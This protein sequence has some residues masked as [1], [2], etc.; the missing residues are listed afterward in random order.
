MYFNQSEGEFM[1]DQVLKR[2]IE[3]AGYWFVG[4]YA[5]KTFENYNELV[6][7]NYF[8][9]EFIN[10]IFREQGRDKDLGGTR[11]RVN[12]LLRIIRDGKIIEA[13]EY[14]IASDRL[15]NKEPRSV[16]MAKEAL[17]VIKI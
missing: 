15:N 7:N 8:K 14:I 2:N 12:A 10:E 16:E 6:S 4:E 9:N 13:L 5:A 11:T 3:S 17:K 1:S